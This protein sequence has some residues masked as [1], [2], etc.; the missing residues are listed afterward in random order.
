MKRLAFA[1]LCAGLALAG[2]DDTFIIHGVT[3]HPVSAADIPNGAVLVKDGKI[4]EVGAKIASP[5]GVRVVDGK[6]LHLYPGLIDS[7][8]QLGLSEIG[9]VRETSDTTELGNFK[10]QLHAAIAVNPSSEHI[11]VARA[12]GIT[13]ALTMPEGGVICG[14]A[15]L[16]HLDGWTIEEMEVRRSA[17]MRMDFPQITTVSSRFSSQTTTPTAYSEAKR[18]YDQQIRELNEFF[19]AAHRYQ[20]A[21]AAGGPGFKTDLKMEAMLPVLEG[22]MPLV[23]RAQREK[24]IREAIQFAEKQKIH[25]V[26]QNG[27]EAYKVLGELKSKNI[28]VTLG[29]TLSLPLEEDDPYDRPFTL[30]AELHKAGVKIAFTS[31]SGGPTKDPRNLPYQAATAV[32]FGLPREEALKALTVYPAEIWGVA[33]QIGSIDKGKWADLML[34]DGDPL[35][36]R[37]QVKQVFIK[38]RA[39]DMENKHRRLYQKYLN[40]P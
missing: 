19:E 28:P 24:T 39:V 25:M 34:T 11:P 33:D 35:E 3:V 37:T 8:T 23:I 38:G 14:Q 36:T 7:G 21:K 15:A 10:P 26:L 2:T 20:K 18:R 32:A 1:L 40:R 13:T 4:V 17:A 31:F 22:K 30:P 27:G 5:R 12:N 9:S 6:G 29:P 16:I